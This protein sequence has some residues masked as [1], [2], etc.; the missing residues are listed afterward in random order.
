MP[1]VH[2]NSINLYYETTGDGEPVVLVH[3]SWGDHHNWAPV[4]PLLSQSFRVVRFDRRGHS[5]SEAGRNQGS[6]AE[7]AD[8]LGE[9]IERLGLAPAH[10]VGN[11]GGAAIAL[12]LAGKRPDLFR[13]LAI[14]EPPL[15]DLLRDRPEFESLLQGFDARIAVVVKLLRAGDMQGAAQRFVETVAFG[16]GA[17]N[18]LPQ[19]IRNTFI[20]NAPTF[21]DESND[22]EG[23]TLDLKSLAAFGKPALVTTGTDSPPFFKPIAE[24]VAQALPLSTLLTFEGAGHVPHLSHTQSYVETV[25]RYCRETDS[26]SGERP[27]LLAAA[28]RGDRR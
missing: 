28:D 3:G 19:A 27:A 2:V 23:L 20:H 13:T 4:V 1:F 25:S 24:A 8:D 17:W 7:D 16:P 22:S 15:V 21:L 11:S 26:R 5:Q 6:F 10:V 9:L 18:T 14:H 12:R